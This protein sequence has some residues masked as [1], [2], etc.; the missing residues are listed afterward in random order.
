MSAPASR[1][2]RAADWLYLLTAVFF[3][4]YLFVYYWTGEG[5]PTLLAIALVPVT[6]ILF[7]LDGLRNNEF[8]PRLPAG[9]NYAIAA[10]YIAVSIAVA[11]YMHTE[12]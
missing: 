5:G 12:Y 3:F 1:P 6:F 10:V 8:Y 2:R 9:A 4:V 7:T 11:V